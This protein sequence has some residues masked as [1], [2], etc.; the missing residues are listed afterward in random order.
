MADIA[1]VRF[2]WVNDLSQPFQDLRDSYGASSFFDLNVKL[3]HSLG[4][5][6]LGRCGQRWSHLNAVDQ[7][8]NCTRFPY[9]TDV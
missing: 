8:E 5:H 6:I 7:L 2:L 3:S 4:S 1:A 9:D